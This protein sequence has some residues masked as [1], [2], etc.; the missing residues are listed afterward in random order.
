[1]VKGLARGQQRMAEMLVVMRSQSKMIVMLALGSFAQKQEIE[2]QDLQEAASSLDR[3]D[4]SNTGP[5][6]VFDVSGQIQVHRRCL[7]C[8]HR[9]SS[10]YMRH[11]WFH[12]SLWYLKLTLYVISKTLFV[13]ASRIQSPIASRGALGAWKWK[14]LFRWTRG[15][16]ALWS[17]LVLRSKVHG[18]W[19]MVF[20]QTMFL[21]R[22]A[23]LWVLHWNWNVTHLKF[24]YSKTRI[25]RTPTKTFETICFRGS[26]LI[27]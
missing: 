26:I 25:S 27:V 8:Y 18:L 17:V 3:W 14:F 24:K 12:Q 2:W 13:G 7:P 19:Q 11:A 6:S 9:F 1:M 21:S 23:F 4:V 10:S 16:V 5:C 20:A 22:S 15:A